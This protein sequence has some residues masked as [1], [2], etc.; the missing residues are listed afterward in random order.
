MSSNDSINIS[1]DQ[2]QDW[3]MLCM[4]I[5]RDIDSVKSDVN[6]IKDDLK[7]YKHF[8]DKKFLEFVQT[9]MEKHRKN[10][11]DI[12]TMQVKVGF[13]A[14]GITVLLTLLTTGIIYLA[15]DIIVNILGI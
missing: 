4:F 10:R 15:K 12:L 14:S 2:K 9:M 5:I 7:D 6:N 3:S 1:G 8:N 13:V 11:E